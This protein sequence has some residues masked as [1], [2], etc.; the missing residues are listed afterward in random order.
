MTRNTITVKNYLK[1]YEEGV[2]AAAITPGHLVEVNS[3]G[4]LQV[5]STEGGNVLPM[6][7]IE[8]SLQ[9]G[10][11]TKAYAA[12]DRVQAWIP[13]RGDIAN[14][15]L[16]DGETVAIGD[17][18]ESAGDGTVKKTVAA[19]S[20]DVIT[21]ASPIVGVALEAVDMSGSAGEDPS[22]RILIRIV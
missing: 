20:G 18:V 12:D 11:I 7:A 5:H 19:E 10:L 1:V 22:N 9:G 17:F 16:A 21:P 3:D 2:A 15:I 6:V 4:K 8:D 13:T 14:M